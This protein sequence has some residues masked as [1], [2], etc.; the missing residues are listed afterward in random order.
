M[1]INK[2]VKVAI[3]IITALVALFPFIILPALMMIFVFTSG[4]PF[5]DPQA[6]NSPEYFNK[7]LPT[8][9]LVFYPLIMCSS[10]F[11][12]ALQ[13]FYVAL[14]IKNKQLTDIIRILFALGMFFMP[15]IA[16]PLYFVAY[17]WNENTQNT[18][19]QQTDT[20]TSLP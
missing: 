11:Q 8:F 6:I 14:V 2:R 1:N 9:F 17:F 12:L 7:F 10:I 18:N 13:V 19:V 15:Y 4:F 20:P 16:M 3:G 5:S